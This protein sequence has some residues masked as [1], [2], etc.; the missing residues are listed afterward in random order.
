MILLIF[1]SVATCEFYAEDC[2][3]FYHRRLNIL[4]KSDQEKLNKA[5]FIF[6]TREEMNYKGE[7]LLK[8]LDEPVLNIQAFII[9]HV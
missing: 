9:L 2:L 5:I 6:T 3:T 1:D 7:K 8:K 4:D